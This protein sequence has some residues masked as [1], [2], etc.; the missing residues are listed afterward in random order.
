MVRPVFSVRLQNVASCPLPCHNTFMR[1][2][3]RN[4]KDN[5]HD[6]K[7]ILV[8]RLS[9]VGDVVRTIP[10][11][12]ALRKR[13]PE[14]VIHWLV[15]D[16]CSEL[17]TGMNGIDELR[18]VPRRQW[19]TLNL[20]DRFRAFTR[21]IRSLRRERYDLYVDYHGILKSGVYGA[22]ARIP[23]RVGYPRGIAKEWNT[24]F[25]NEFIPQRSP[26]ISRYERN[27][28]LTRYFDSDALVSRPGLPLSSADRAFATDFLKQCKLEPGR[29]AFLYPGTSQRGRYKRWNPDRYATV[30]EQLY[31]SGLPS[32]IGW[33]PGEEP[34][35]ERIRSR[36]GVAVHVPPLTSLKELGALIECAGVFIGGDTGPMHMASLLGTPVVTLFGPSDPVINEPATF[37]PFRIV[38]TSVDCSP[39]RKKDCRTLVCMDGISPEMVLASVNDLMKETGH[40][41]LQ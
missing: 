16:R 28:A 1:G 10:A 33:G 24:L 7:K 2:T 6:P 30:V 31:E 19:K 26:R 14:S 5:L 27:L 9:A 37:T 11:I 12:L 41:P 38:Y 3:T 4:K 39:C 13:Y 22:M 40:L 15:E 32:V 21:F 17:L 36:S 25:N 20:L 23:R 18:I 35:V 8:A 34:V 29:Y